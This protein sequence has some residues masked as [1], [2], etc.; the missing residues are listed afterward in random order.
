MN[1]YTYISRFALATFS[2]VVLVACW[3]QAQQPVQAQSSSSSSS[4]PL[5]A[6]PDFSALVERASPA[7]VSIEASMDASVRQQGA[8]SAGSSP[9]EEQMQEFYR[10]FFGQPMPGNPGQ[11]MPGNPGQPMPRGGVSF[12]SG[13]IIS[14]D[15]YVLTNHHV[16]EGTNKVTVH[17]ADRREVAATIIGSDPS[18]DVAVLKINEKNLPVLAIGDSQ[19]LKPG[20]WVVAIGSPFGF[21]RSVTAGIVSALGRPSVDGSQRYVPFIQTDVAINRGNSGGPLLN[22]RGEV[23]GINSQIFSNSGGYMGVSFAIP[24]Q[25]AM[26]AFDQIKAT[27]KVSRGQLGVQIGDVP[28]EDMQELGLSKAEGAFV[29]GV[30]N[31]S[32]AANAGI[33]PGDVIIA[34][35]GQPI[36]KSSDLPPLVGALKPGAKSQVTIMRAG[37][38]QVLPVVLSAL[39]QAAPAVA[40][41]RTAPSDNSGSKIGF[42]VEAVTPETRRRL[43]L[44]NGGI[45]IAQVNLRSLSQVIAKGDVVLEVNGRP[46]GSVTEFNAEMARI[47]SGERVRLLIRNSES[48]ALLTLPM[49]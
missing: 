27:G 1:K 21:E 14:S 13:F 17:L 9:E 22:T 19:N 43:D 28:A 20:Q 4:A 38:K 7:V 45:Q 2:A 46:V 34:F 48:T 26:N 29:G 39:D 31:G 40:P 8:E 5:V 49:P 41:G 12:G 44:P 32:A 42:S 30:L 18:T 47:K 6:L 24:I 36:V 11:P 10:R 37:R 15:G 25:T 23:V 16:I 33:R 35:N 3:Q